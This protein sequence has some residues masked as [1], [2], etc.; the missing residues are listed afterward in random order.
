MTNP[1]LQGPPFISG[2]P[3]STGLLV[4]DCDPYLRPSRTLDI[5]LEGIIGGMAEAV[6][7]ES[8]SP[9][10]DRMELTGAKLID[11]DGVVYKGRATRE[12]DHPVIAFS[13]LHPGTYRLHALRAEYVLEASHNLYADEIRRAFDCGDEESTVE[14]PERLVYTYYLAPEE[15]DRFTCDVSAG[16]A[17]YVGRLH[18]VETHL[19]RR[20]ETKRRRDN[21]HA[22]DVKRD[23]EFER[24]SW[25]T[26]LRSMTRESGDMEDRS[27][28]P[29]V[30][31]RVDEI[32]AM[33]E[34]HNTSGE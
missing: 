11:D 32:D 3:D 5:S 26:V 8:V 27:W 22:D 20:W 23:P 6:F 33:T 1:G 4:V 28:V 30:S 31:A 24:E 29:I 15:S 17:L 7:E 13:S 10:G 34:T 16:S 19:P 14:C 21:F 25:V 9:H 18:L 12:G 2:S